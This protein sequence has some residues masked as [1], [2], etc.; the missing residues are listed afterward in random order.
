MW[1]SCNAGSLV[2]VVWLLAAAIT[3][4]AIF[5]GVRASCRDG[6]LSTI[7]RRTSV[8]LGAGVLAPFAVGLVLSV[9][10]VACAS[11]RPVALRGDDLLLV[12]VG[13]GRSMYALTPLVGVVCAASLALTRRPLTNGPRSHVALLAVTAVA[14]GLP[15]L[16]NLRVDPDLCLGEPLEMVREIQAA[17]EAYRAELGAYANISTSLGA[18]Q[19]INH[20]ALYPSSP[21]EPGFHRRGWG[22]SCARAACNTGAG[23]SSLPVRVDGPVAFGYSTIAGRAGERP[24]A[25][26]IMRGEPVQWQVPKSDW[27]IVTAVGRTS[28]GEFVTVVG[29]SFTRRLLIDVGSY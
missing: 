10:T 28:S 22:V 3:S 20:G 24:T 2:D 18:N 26:I 11:V 7:A 29:S 25:K 12:A 14:S 13:R 21:H 15:S 27:Y 23:W 19:D 17:Q 9:R 8:T 5:A 1:S 6:G 16:M 4:V